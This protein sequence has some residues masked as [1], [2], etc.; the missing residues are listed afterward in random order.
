ME[1][2]EVVQYSYNI[3]WGEKVLFRPTQAVS[4]FLFWNTCVH[5]HRR[6]RVG[7]PLPHMLVTHQWAL[8]HERCA[9][10]L[11]RASYITYINFT[12]SPRCY[13]ARKHHLDES[14][15]YPKTSYWW[16]AVTVSECI[17]WKKRIKSLF[18]VPVKNRCLFVV[19]FLFSKQG[20]K[21]RSSCKTRS[22][23]R[24]SVRQASFITR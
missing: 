6:N 23:L 2:A 22:S 14:S 8:F 7:M 21:R 5:S 19:S 17:L 10:C 15:K 4:E 9:L 12:P 18:P 16:L 3:N 13:N 11:L 24:D 20:F 1:E